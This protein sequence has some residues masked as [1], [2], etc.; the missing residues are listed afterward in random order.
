[1]DDNPILFRR[2]QKHRQYRQIIDAYEQSKSPSYVAR[3][4]MLTEQEAALVCGVID[5]L[6][7][8][9]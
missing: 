2:L 7:E 5:R 8:E 9:K 4:F 6:K 1:M 3:A